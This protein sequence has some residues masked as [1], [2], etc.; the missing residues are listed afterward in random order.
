MLYYR[1]DPEAARDALEQ[2]QGIIRER[3]WSVLQKGEE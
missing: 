2:I 3:A 1:R